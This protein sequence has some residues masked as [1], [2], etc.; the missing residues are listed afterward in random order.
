MQIIPSTVAAGVAQTGLQA[1]EEA[2][3]RSRR[4]Q[5]AYR[6][7]R[8]VQETAEI[9]LRALDEN[10]QSRAGVHVEVSGD[11][12]EQASGQDAA[13]T[14]AGPSQADGQAVEAIKPVNKL[15]VQ[16]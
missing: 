10:D 2:R 1:Q 3:R 9:H 11:L 12:P 16:A 8:H 14:P 15:D 7:T 13:R 5:Q 4:S 6:Q